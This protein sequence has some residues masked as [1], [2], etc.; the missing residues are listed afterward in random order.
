MALKSD[1]RQWLVRW[2]IPDL[3]DGFNRGNAENAGEINQGF[4]KKHGLTRNRNRLADGRSVVG[5]SWTEIDQT[6]LQ[7]LEESQSNGSELCLS[8]PHSPVNDYV[9]ITFT[10]TKWNSVPGWAR[11]F[12]VVPPRRSLWPPH[13]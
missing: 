3:R 7:D 12:R 13:L 9:F 5:E 8:K 10:A 2:S 4:I 6:L 1:E 11:R